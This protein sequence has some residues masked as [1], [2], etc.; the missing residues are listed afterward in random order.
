MFAKKQGCTHD[1]NSERQKNSDDNA[2]RARGRCL[3]GADRLIGRRIYYVRTAAVT[4][5][6]RDEDDAAAFRSSLASMGSMLSST[7]A[8]A[9]SGPFRVSSMVSS[10][11]SSS[12]TGGSNMS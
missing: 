10:G 6:I 11:S 1:A 4:Y 9:R 12:L 5:G 7:E 3:Q 2:F 8:V